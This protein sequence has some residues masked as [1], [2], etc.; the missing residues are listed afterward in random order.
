MEPSPYYELDFRI[1]PEQRDEFDERNNTL[2]RAR[3]ERPG[4]KAGP[5][6]HALAFSTRADSRGKP[7]Q[8]RTIITLL[9]ETDRGV[10]GMRLVLKRNGSLAEEWK[11]ISL[12]AGQKQLYINYGALP[13]PPLYSDMFQAYLYD[14]AGALLD[15]RSENE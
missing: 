8:L 12:S 3:F 15:S 1:A 5:R 4:A 13:G 11:G 7:T 9:N 14:S 2:A 10:N 6:I